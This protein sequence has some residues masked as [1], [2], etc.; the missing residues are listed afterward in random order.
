MVVL[1]LVSEFRSIFRDTET[2]LAAFSRDGKAQYKNGSG[3]AL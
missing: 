1:T 2:S 3:P